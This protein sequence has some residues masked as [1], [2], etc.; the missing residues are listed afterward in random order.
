MGFETGWFPASTPAL[1]KRSNTTAWQGGLPCSPGWQKQWGWTMQLPL[2][3]RGPGVEWGSLNVI[4][5]PRDLICSGKVE[6]VSGHY[7]GLLV[8]AAVQPFLPAAV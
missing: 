7:E 5:K 2:G 8:L 3:G 6:W 4:S 1:S